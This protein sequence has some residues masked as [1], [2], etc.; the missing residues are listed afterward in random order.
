MATSK[1]IGVNTFDVYVESR[2]DSWGRE[3]RLGYVQEGEDAFMGPV[4]GNNILATLIQ[5]KGEIRMGSTA[6]DV[7]PDDWQ[8]E[9]IVSIIHRD[10][11]HLASVLRAYYCGRGR[12][13]VERLELAE[14]LL[15]RQIGKRSYYAY[16]DTAFA[17]VSGVL[18]GIAIA[19]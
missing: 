12:H 13:A 14:L 2:L 1:G 18:K 6:Q 3:F 17:H 11:P 16:R 15:G 9:Q 5:N 8:M 10:Y 7:S 4:Y 19:A